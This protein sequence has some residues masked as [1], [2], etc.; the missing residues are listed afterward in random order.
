MA[1]QELSPVS[2]A[3]TRGRLTWL[4]NE[5]FCGEKKQK[6]SIL[7]NANTT[8]PFI[9]QINCILLG[10]QMPLEKTQTGHIPTELLLH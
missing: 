7:P 9:F 8:T 6:G 5:L 4:P 1:V 10:N 3:E 2:E